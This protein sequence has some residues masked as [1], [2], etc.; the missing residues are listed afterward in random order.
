MASFRNDEP[1]HRATMIEVVELLA[2]HEYAYIPVN[3]LDQ[4]YTGCNLGVTGIN[5]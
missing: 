5:T 2:K 4:P 3:T 1:V